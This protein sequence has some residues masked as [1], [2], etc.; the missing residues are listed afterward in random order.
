MSR[1]SDRF[2]VVTGGPGE[3][4]TTL[5][6]L[7]RASVEERLAF[8]TANPPPRSGGGRGPAR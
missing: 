7:P 5:I 1:D 4:K 8:V 6:E 3:G 2:F